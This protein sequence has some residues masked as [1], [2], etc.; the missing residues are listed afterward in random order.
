M[1]SNLFSDSEADISDWEIEE[2][3]P[4]LSDQFIQKYLDEREALIEQEKTQRSDYAFCQSLSPLAV[5]ACAIASRI[6]AEELRTIWTNEYEKLSP[7]AE[8]VN[9]YPGI[10]FTLAKE[11][12]EMTKSWQIIRKLLKGALLHAHFDAMIYVEWLIDQVLNTDGMAIQADQNLSTAEAR[13]GGLIE[14]RYTKTSSAG[15]EQLVSLKSTAENF[16]DGGPEGFKAWLKRRCIITLEESL[17]H[18]H[19]VDIIWQKFKSCFPI[20]N[21][22]IFY[23]PILRASVQ[24]LLHQLTDGFRMALLFDYQQEDCEEPETG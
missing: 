8:G 10:L 15:A 3:L 12:M 2:G 19:G 14:F 9:Y 5:E 20:L 13:M 23:E 7:H 21:S 16:P 17:D 4:Q 18:H 1:A 22:M 11:R 6:R 24:H